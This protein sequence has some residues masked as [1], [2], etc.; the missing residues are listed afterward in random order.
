MV[1]DDLGVGL[2]PSLPGTGRDSL[3]P[4]LRLCIEI[5]RHHP[6]DMYKEQTLLNISTYAQCTTDTSLYCPGLHI[7]HL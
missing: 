6:S 7:S 1:I 3:R 2:P 4:F 5:L